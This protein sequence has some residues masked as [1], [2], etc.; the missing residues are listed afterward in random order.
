[1]TINRAIQ[2]ASNAAFRLGLMAS[3]TWIFF[4]QLAIRHD[5]KI[6]EILMTPVWIG[7]GGWL[8]YKHNVEKKLLRKFK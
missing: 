8:I 3:A 6:Y 1:M 7:W 5:T 4:V 2:T